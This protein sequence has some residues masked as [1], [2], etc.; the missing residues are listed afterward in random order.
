M[1]LKTIIWIVITFLAVIIFI[2]KIMTSP[3]PCD[4][5]QIETTDRPL[6]DTIGGLTAPFLSALGSVLLF[7]TIWVQIA[8][9]KK[10]DK[11]QRLSRTY[12][13]FI[14][15]FDLIHHDI[16]NFTFYE[17]G[18]VSQGVR[19]IQ[20][21]VLDFNTKTE[22]QQVTDY[23]YNTQF[24]E[25]LFLLTSTINL[26]NSIATSKLKEQD[27]INLFNKTKVLYEGKIKGCFDTI[28]GYINDRNITHEH[29]VT[30][31]DRISALNLQIETPILSI[32][33]KGNPTIIPVANIL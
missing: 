28:A 10:Q 19:A 12:E 30:F 6:G 3:A 29:A 9:N 8:T 14:H 25:L 21:F 2:P 22:P 32:G 26:T 27:K 18:Q 4:W 15:E 13:G 16:S 23:F 31:R 5:M 24:G 17:E 33:T 1:N 11:A 7:I 20:L